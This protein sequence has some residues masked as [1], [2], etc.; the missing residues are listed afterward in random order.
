MHIGALKH[1]KP[2]SVDDLALLGDDIVVI[3]HVFTDIEV[4]AFNLRLCLLDE[5]RDHAALQRHIFF[6]T[7]HFHDFSHAVGSETAH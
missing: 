3:Y 1:G 4:V 2:V 5:T 6:H 7:D